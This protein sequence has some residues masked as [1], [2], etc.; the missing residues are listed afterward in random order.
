M[1]TQHI[2][3]SFVP[4]HNATEFYAAHAAGHHIQYNSNLNFDWEF[5]GGLPDTYDTPS[6]VGGW[7]TEDDVEFD[8]NLNLVFRYV[9]YE[10]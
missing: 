1:D 2:E 7:M 9:V 10:D 3:K 6:D 5:T 4:I 8:E